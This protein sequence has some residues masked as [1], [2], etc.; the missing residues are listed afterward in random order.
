MV[1]LYLDRGQS[2]FLY[3]TKFST[4]VIRLLSIW[5][6]NFP[7]WIRFCWNSE[8]RRTERFKGS[9]TSKWAIL[10]TKKILC[11]QLGIIL[12]K[13]MNKS[14][15]L[16]VMYQNCSCHR[17]VLKYALKCM[18]LQVV[19]KFIFYLLASLFFLSLDF[20]WQSSCICVCVSGTSTS[21]DS[22]LICWTLRCPLTLRP[23][24]DRF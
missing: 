20:Y 8:R 18:G 19:P 15:V 7:S 12:K 21:T 10:L 5:T 14:L 13:N 9:S 6:W 17:H 23:V 24:S 11:C 1:K 3:S 16:P 2:Y 22:C 4:P